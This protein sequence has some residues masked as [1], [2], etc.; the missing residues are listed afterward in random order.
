MSGQTPNETLEQK[1]DKLTATVDARFD[2]ID[3]RFEAVDKRFE[4]VDKRFEAVDKRFDAVDKRFD[5]VDKRFD[6]VD[7]RFDDVAEALVEQREYTEFAFDKLRTDMIAGSRQ[8]RGDI[9]RLERKLDRV[10][11]TRTRTKSPGRRRRS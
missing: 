11:D 10:L 9:S 6:D 3:K 2:T 4:T 1:V 7:K 5:A 8:I